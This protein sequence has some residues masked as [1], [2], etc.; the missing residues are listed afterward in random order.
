MVTK[1]R[2][3]EN[4]YGE[5]NSATG[6]RKIDRMIRADIRSAKSREQV[7]ELKRR[8]DYLCT[9][10]RSPA[11]KTRFGSQV[12][13]LL[14]VAKEENERTVRL[15]NQVAKKKGWDVEYD[16]WGSN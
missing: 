10:T 14:S 5:V 3:G 13:R 2:Q 15:A 11:W 6:I 16:P 7:T 1:E 4:L 12:D 9:L 8:S